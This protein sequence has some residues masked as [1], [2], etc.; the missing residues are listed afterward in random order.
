MV[1]ETLGISW[2]HNNCLVLADISRLSMTKS[3]P[4]FLSASLTSS[5]SSP[6][7]TPH[8]FIYTLHT[9]TPKKRRKK[10]LPAGSFFSR[11]CNQQRCSL[12]TR[13]R[14]INQT[15]L[16]CLARRV[17][18]PLPSPF[19]NQEGEQRPSLIESDRPVSA[20]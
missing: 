1:T 14:G 12:D 9:H 4:F 3:C 16:C 17:R 11:S 2:Q 10:F 7:E 20:N 15:E 6:C 18:Q 8:L 5:R 13:L 19:F